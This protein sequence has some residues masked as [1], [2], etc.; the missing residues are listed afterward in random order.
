MFQSA[1][2]DDVVQTALQNTSG[3]SLSVAAT[4]D[5]SVAYAKAFGRDRLA[6]DRVATPQ[7]I[8]SIA[9]VTKQF[10]AACVLLL[11]REGRLRLDDRVAQYFP[12]ATRAGDITIAHL[13]SHTSGYPDYY[14]LG[15]ADE[16]KLAP[17]TPD[18]I[19]ERYAES[20]LQFEP[21]SAWSYSNTGFHIAG[22]IVELVSETPFGDFL[23]ARVLRPAD[24]SASFLNDPPIE[25]LPSAFGYTRFCLGPV[26][27]TDPE[28]AGWMYS[29]GGIA[30]AAG[31]LA[32]WHVALMERR[33]LD[34]AL[35]REMTTPY[36]LHDGGPSVPALGWFVEKRGAFD[37]IQHSGGLAG[38]ASQT[39]VSLERRCSI[40]VL[41]NGD[42]VQVGQLAGRLFERLLP[43]AVPPALPEPQART[44]PW[45]PWLT[46]LQTGEIDRAR[47]TP[48]FAR[49]LTP[50]R[51]DDARVGLGGLGE[52]REA[53]TVVA[54]ERGAMP[55]TKVR[56]QFEKQS[57]DVLY[58]ETT[59][60]RLA[61]FNAYP[62]P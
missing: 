47:V 1:E 12:R 31:D 52:I 45:T 30:A 36:P 6:P 7:T 57:V 28:R 43:G 59:D 9:S 14:P 56:I 39:I 38:F 3:P 34:D 13:L 46:A 53:R 27:R 4:Y 17:A 21:G 16:E 8:Y 54:G 62:I 25:L 55:W 23:V 19:I 2:L 10:T 11:A 61:E 50:Q 35:L 49:Y 22:R 15:F 33:V 48:E 5:G 60:G 42:H 18:E 37:V 44:G 32:M 29:S 41:A 58:R 40:V 20:D 24:M 26:R 51:L